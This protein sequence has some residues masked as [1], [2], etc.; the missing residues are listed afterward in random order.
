MCYSESLSFE[1]QKRGCFIFDGNHEV[2][3]MLLSRVYPR[4]A[5]QRHQQVNARQEQSFGSTLAA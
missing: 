5:E 1:G 4:K 2:L 3:L